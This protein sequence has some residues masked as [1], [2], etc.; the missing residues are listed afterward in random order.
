MANFNDL[1]ENIRK[2]IIK[3]II[4]IFF[5]LI[6]STIAFILSIFIFSKRLE[7]IKLADLNIETA[8]LKNAIE[9]Y[10]IR[11]GE[12]PK[13][14]GN[15][16]NLKNIKNYQGNYT[17]ELFYGDEKIHEVHGNIEKGI[18]S[19]NKVF[20]KKDNKG[21]WVYDIETGK[22]SPNIEY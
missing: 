16:N 6:V 1:N 20:S 7:R 22:I 19:T 17:F 11:T 12:Y 18:S 21:G 3:I 14:E 5:L 2:K 4:K 15:E 13:L 9:S 10:K 8:R